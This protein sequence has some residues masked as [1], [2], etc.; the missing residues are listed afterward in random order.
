[1]VEKVNAIEENLRRLIEDE[2]R[3][4]ERYGKLDWME[5]SMLMIQD[6]G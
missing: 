1:M 2:A 3:S 6:S 4:L 5:F